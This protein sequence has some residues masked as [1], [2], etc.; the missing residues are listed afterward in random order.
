MLDAAV[1]TTALRGIMDP[2]F[3]GWAGYPASP[4]A[5]GLRWAAAL[6]DY[7]D[8]LAVPPGV[9]A[10]QQTAG[11]AAFAAIFQPDPLVGNGAAL[12]ASAAA[13]YTVALVAPSGVTVPP[14]AP[15]VVTLA[16]T[17]D[18]AAAAAALAA[19]IDTWARTGTYTA[20]AGVPVPWS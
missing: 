18:G 2:S 12:L 16:P 3:V 1:L 9:T 5:A 20:P 6:R 8:G 17:S 13:A 10:L 19:V 11:Q 7:F 15:L 4:A 14:P